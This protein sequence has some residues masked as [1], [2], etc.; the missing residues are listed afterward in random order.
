MPYKEAR[1]PT[2]QI[3]LFILTFIT[4]TLAGVEWIFG[5][6]L[7]YSFLNAEIF[8]FFTW[9]QAQ[10][11]LLFSIPFLTVLTCHE[12]GH[13]LTARYYRI[14]VSLPYYIP[15][16]FGP[17]STIGT[18][19]A[20]IRI[21]ERIIS[22]KEFFDVGIAGP[23]AGFA[24]ALP[25]LYYGFTH[26][27]DPAYIFKIH[28]EYAQYGFN[29]AE[30]VYQQA[31]GISFAL[32]KNLLFL[33]FEHYVAPNPAAIPNA[34]EIIHYPLLFAGYLSLFFTAL[35]LLPIGQLDG[36]HI[37]YGLIGQRLF[38][39]VSPVLFVLFIGYAGLGIFSPHTALEDAQW[40][41]PAYGLYLYVVLRGVVPSNR[42][43]FLVIAGILVFQYGMAY[44]FPDIQGYMGW[45]A[46]GFLLGRFLGVY[47]P[48]A[49]DE[50][51]LSRGRKL[52][53][54]L[55]LLIFV[56]CFSPTPFVVQ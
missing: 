4:T 47:H 37:L 21:K 26:L 1:V 48:A 12:F 34:Y 52:L 43:A 42:H 53:G 24:V 18:M 27:P 44:L 22:K 3:F 25:L 40:I 17:V 54:Y 41:F 14:R 56:L 38:N 45:L 32:G 50:S 13:Y 30:K 10:Q 33:F 46:F 31:S 49:I 39:R 16:W 9:T 20:F 29:Y 36:G 51:P 35:N 5:R 7:F 28:P 55:A 2:L 19:G 6:P 11:G 8:P 23:L 15:V